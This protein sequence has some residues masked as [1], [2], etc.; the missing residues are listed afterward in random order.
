MTFLI[1]GQLTTSELM[2][3][4]LYNLM[5]HRR[6]CSGP[7]GGR[8][9]VRRGRRLPADL[10]RHR[11]ADLSRQVIN[12]TLRLST[13]DGF[14]RMALADTTIGG[15][16]PIRAGEAV[17]V[18]TERSI[19]NPNGATTSNSSTP[20]RFDP[21]RQRPAPPE[22]SNRS[23]PARDPASGRQ[24]AL[25]EATMAIAPAGAPLSADRPAT[26]RKWDSLLSC[27]PAGF[28]PTCFWRVLTIVA[29]PRRRTPHQRPP[30]QHLRP[31]PSRPA[32]R[33]PSCHGSNLGTC[34]A[35]AKLLAEEA[36]GPGCSTNGREPPDRL[37]PAP[38][39][40]ADARPSIAGVV[41]GQPAAQ[42][43]RTRVHGPAAR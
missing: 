31:R 9:G 30:T 21:P 6:C 26:C 22:C 42:R 43:R 23:A 12:E 32:P 7:V 25:H 16:Y 13:G 41:S 18:L 20:D 24:F 39:S 1:A 34:R 17:T 10:R 29:A 11:Q 36:T 8:R 3:N 37:T 35:L 5:H 38:C 4:T 27:R 19:V 40:E 14:D 15:T 2:P 28:A 33:W